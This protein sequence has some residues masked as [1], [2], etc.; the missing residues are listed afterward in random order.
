VKGSDQHPLYQW[1]EAKT[2][3]HP[4]WNFAKFLVSEDGAKVTFFN[5]SVQ[6]MDEKIISSIQ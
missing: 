3:K 2:G 1:L 4:D 5:S 6:P